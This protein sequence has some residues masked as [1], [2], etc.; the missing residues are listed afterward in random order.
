MRFFDIDTFYND[1][2]GFMDLFGV[3]DERGRGREGDVLI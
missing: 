3:L 2:V 1:V